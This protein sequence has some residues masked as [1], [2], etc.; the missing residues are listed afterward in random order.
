M[1]PNI[2][3]YKETEIKTF[4]FSFRN[5]FMIEAFRHILSTNYLLNIECSKEFI[6][7]R[8]LTNENELI[9]TILTGTSGGGN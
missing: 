7:G 9:F 1:F 8:L 6:L 4:F 3:L 5:I 2:C